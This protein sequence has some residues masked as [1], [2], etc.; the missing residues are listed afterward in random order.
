MLLLYFKKSFLTIIIGILP[1]A[2]LLSCHNVAQRNSVAQHKNV[3]RQ[4]ITSL[5]GRVVESKGEPVEGIEI[6]FQPVEIG[7]RDILPMPIDEILYKTETEADGQ[8][9]ISNIPSDPMELML[10]HKDKSDYKIISVAIEGLTIYANKYS[11][12][13]EMQFVI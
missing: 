12:L 3:A 7:R 11:Y 1:C 10:L 6:G 2:I 4:E 8:F 13:R 5:S 9:S